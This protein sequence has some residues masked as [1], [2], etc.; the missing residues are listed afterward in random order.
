MAV[1]TG[2]SQA[3]QHA[4][5]YGV[6]HLGVAGGTQA[7]AG[8]FA[9]ASL[10]M[11]PIYTVYATN[12]AIAHPVPVALNR[13]A[14][15]GRALADALLRDVHGRR[16]V[17]LVTFSL[18]ANVAFECL[19]CLAEAG[20][21]D[22]VEDVVLAGACLVSHP[23]TWRRALQAVAG[24]AINVYSSRD[25]L[26]G[27]IGKLGHL[28]RLGIAGTGKISGVPGLE[29]VDVSHII[30]T[31]TAY[32]YAFDSVL[33]A[34]PSQPNER[35][36]STGDT[37]GA[38]MERHSYALALHQMKCSLTG[39]RS[40]AVAVRNATPFRLR[41][42][43]SHLS[44]GKWVETPPDTLEPESAVLMAVTGSGTLSGVDG[45]VVYESLDEGSA[46]HVTCA[47]GVPLRGRPRGAVVLGGGALEGEATAS[48]PEC[49]TEDSVRSL[50]SVAKK[51]SCEGSLRLKGRWSSGEHVFLLKFTSGN[52]LVP[53]DDVPGS[54]WLMPTACRPARAPAPKSLRCCI[55]NRTSNEL[56]M[57]WAQP[58]PLTPVK[59]VPPGYTAVLLFGDATEFAALLRATFQNK[60]VLV[61]L[62]AV[63][64]TLVSSRKATV[65]LALSSPGDRLSDV[66]DALTEQCGAPEGRCFANFSEDAEDSSDVLYCR[67]WMDGDSFWCSVKSASSCV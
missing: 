63:R 52:E 49:L 65:Q 64:A 8:F 25:S 39:K 48:P 38:S 35:T 30:D 16:P 24:R 15:S 23:P 18:G 29:N 50:M 21:R 19:L 20:R 59:I 46:F 57:V 28:T 11:I 7:V 13:A 9:F 43:A 44:A 32:F 4:V 10:A 12:Q 14:K 2:R 22:I 31:H 53:T 37:P 51:E 45:V 6:A 56:S 34:I 55:V 54:G 58:S 41:L 33:A 67:Y 60:G 1:G 36:L 3:Q 27:M 40:S 26:L 42:A 5:K 66:G 62:A 17:T 47:F 61:C